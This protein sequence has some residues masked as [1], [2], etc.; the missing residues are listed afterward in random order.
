MGMFLLILIIGFISGRLHVIRQ[1][2]MPMLAQIIT[3]VFLP[4][5]IFY[6]TTTSASRQLI[7]D[8]LLVILLAVIFYGF[9]IGFSYLLA[10]AM[11][12]KRDKDRIFQFAFIFGNTAF[13]GMPLLNA[14]FPQYGLLFMCLF[15]LID[16]PVFW[17][18]GIWLSTAR[19]RE[20]AR[21]SPK[22]LITPN[23]IAI[24]LAFIVA[25]VEIPLPDLLN[26]TL[27][28]VS[29]ATPALCI[30]YLG[31]MIC[32]SNIGQIFKRKELY[33]LILVKM[34]L[35]PL[36]FG[37]ILSL[38]PLPFEMRACM[39]LTA[40]LP[41]MTVVPMISEQNGHEGAYATGLTAISLVACVATIPL[42]ALAVL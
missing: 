7:V 1:E 26:D 36:S 39:V 23:T 37:L 19:D 6:S 17:T 30:L 8:N 33:A 40:A 15:S 34:V 13:V 32:F 27:Q 20:P 38:L 21:F 35:L 18:Y 24:A 41:V 29:G 28:L 25:L 14:A 22:S 11:R 42:V 31:A 2:M 3:K 10:K 4:I 16:Q 12:L 9:M 5:M